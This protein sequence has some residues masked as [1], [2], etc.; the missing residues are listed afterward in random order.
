MTKIVIFLGPSLPLEQ[1]KCTLDAVYLP[2]A[3]QS[4]LISA[5]QI[6]QPD[7]IG[8]IDGVFLQRPSVWHKEILYALSQGI[9]VYGASSMGALRAAETESFGMVGVG[10]IYQMYA[11]GALIDDDEVA[12]VHGSAETGYKPLSEPMINI[13]ATLQLAQEQGILSEELHHQLIAIAKSIYFAE[14]TFAAI[15]HKASS[16]GVA[17]E[18]LAALQTFTT[19][20]YVDLKRQDAVLLLQL[21]RE[22]F[23]AASADPAEAHLSK[24]R[25]FNFAQ[26]HVYAALYEGERQVQSQGVQIPLRRIAEYVALHA[27]DFDDLNFHSLNRM[28]AQVLAALLGVT[29][30]SAEIEQEKQRFCLKHK[31]QQNSDLN[32][33]LQNNDMTKTEFQALMQEMAICRRLHRWFLSRQAYQRNI[34]GLLNELRLQNCYAEWADVAG[35]QERLLQEHHVDLNTSHYRNQTLKELLLNH[36]RTTDCC[37]PIPLQAWALEAGFLNTA[38]LQVELMRAKAARDIAID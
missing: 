7:V 12:L 37:I 6:H 3:A 13:R 29:V 24:T 26:T 19:E 4:D 2:P 21:L 17:S 11:S 27:A 9:S 32:Q 36:L 30:E 20:H 38:C 14:R 8:L 18:A 16:A 33:W 10:R 22:R 25:D 5:V 35:Q 31:L 15:L 34:K 23:V 28:L 1:A